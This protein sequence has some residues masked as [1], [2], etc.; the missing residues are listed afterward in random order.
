MAINLSIATRQI[1]TSDVTLSFLG[2]GSPTFPV[3]PKVTVTVQ[4]ANLPTFFARIWSRAA[5]TVRATATAEAFKPSNLSG[6]GGA[7]VPI[8]PRCVNPFLIP[9]CDPGPDGPLLASAYPAVGGV[10]TFRFNNFRSV[11]NN[12]PFRRDE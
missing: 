7:V 11:L 3:N 9:N 5:L 2:S 8:A 12:N 10:P 1:Q 4:N 6:I